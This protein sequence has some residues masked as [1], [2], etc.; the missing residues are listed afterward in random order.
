MRF[1]TVNID[2]FSYH[3]FFKKVNIA[4]KNEE[5]LSLIVPKKSTLLLMAGFYFR[6]S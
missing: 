3:R 1:S 2:D 6:N 4:K 5:N